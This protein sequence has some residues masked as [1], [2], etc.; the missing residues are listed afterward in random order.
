MKTFISIISLC[1]RYTKV[2]CSS[3][4]RVILIIYSLYN[5]PKFAIEK[6]PFK[7]RFKYGIY[8]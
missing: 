8:S 4:Y 5:R 2:M 3:L 1:F 7:Y 6:I